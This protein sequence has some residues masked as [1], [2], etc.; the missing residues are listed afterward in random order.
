[1]YAPAFVC[2]ELLLL[3]EN[4]TKNNNNSKS[5]CGLAPIGNVV[6]LFF[7]MQN[8]RNGIKRKSTQC[9]WNMLMW[10]IRPYEKYVWNTPRR[11]TDKKRPDKKR[12]RKKKI[13]R[14]KKIVCYK[15]LIYFNMLHLRALTNQH[16]H[17]CTHLN[18]YTVHTRAA[19]GVRM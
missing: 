12:E 10:R 14:E 11:Y 13:R 4:T 7:S 1:M 17:A 19:F 3:Q 8:T 15:L 9:S 16:T 18:T 5:I 2:Y 6:V